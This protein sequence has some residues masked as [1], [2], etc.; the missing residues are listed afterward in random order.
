MNYKVIALDVDGTLITDDHRLTEK[1]REAVRAMHS[2]GAK[3]V[4]CTGRGGNS[5]AP[6]LEQLGLEGVMITHNGA[7]VIDYARREVLYSCAIELEEIRPVIAYCRDKGIH[8]DLCSP[9]E[10]YVDRITDKERAMYS[11]F[12]LTP[13]EVEN[14]ELV[15]DMVVKFTLF[16]PE[17]VMDQV[18]RDWETIGS[19]LRKIR[20]G[21]QFIDIMSPSVSKGDALKHVCEGWGIAAEE[22]MAIG[23]YYNDIEMIE[24]AGLGVAMLNSPDGVKERA[25]VV[26]AVS[27]NEDGVAQAIYTYALKA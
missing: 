26:T 7:V 11:R 6:V 17:E 23:N 10:L 20:S 14:V 3:V 24:W 15:D 27:N 2:Q 5:A 21:V 25:D 8:F 16:G 9:Y 1:T 12:E 22:A 4:L 18:E 13:L 19:P